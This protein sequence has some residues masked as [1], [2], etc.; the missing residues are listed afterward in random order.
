MHR[1]FAPA[2]AGLLTGVLALPG[3]AV[4]DVAPDT[5]T[6]PA[7]A[8]ITI[9]G[10]GY[11]HGHGM[12]QYGAEGAA[13][14]GLTYQQ[15]AEFYYAGTTW[16]TT[17]GRIRVQITADTTPADLV[18][19]AR[20]GLTLRDSAV[21]GRVALPD[22]GATQWRVDV[23]AAGSAVSY[24]TDT[25]H[26]FGTLAG[27]GEFFAGGKPITL[28]TPAGERAYRGRLRT[29]VTSSGAAVTVN[30]LGI[31]SYLRGVVPL[32]IP[33]SWSPEAVRAQAVAA[34]TYAAYER[35]HPRASVF[36]ICDTTSCQVYGGYDAEHWAANEAIRATRGQVLTT[37]DGPAFTQFGSSNGGWSAAGSAPYLS[38]REDPYDGWTGNPVHT[39]TVRLD[40]TAIEKRWPKVGDLTGIAV[41]S[42]DG[43][44]EWGGR[45]RSLTLTGTAGTVVVS[46]DTLR[47]A[48]GLRSTW[49][50]FSV[51]S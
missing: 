35:A 31:E 47:S 39:W 20:P 15:I 24:L 30:A 49:L 50:T 51:A 21:P 9:T 7:S 19:R 26:P 45:V 33:A 37:G 6:V 46:G 32:E 1:A 40:D 11:G 5:W 42:R 43:N 29:A 34:R 10:H 14:M 12:S 27:R 25:W 4:A 36:Q 23:G 17:R 2:L 8:R 22:N 13:R 48:L 44:G 28:V 41:T 16:G 38:A 3:S 18:V